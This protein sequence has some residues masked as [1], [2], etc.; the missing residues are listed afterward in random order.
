M[1]RLRSFSVFL[2]LTGTALAS[3]P[4]NAV[5]QTSL[6]QAST[7]AGGS[8]RMLLLDFRADWCGPC[9]VMEAEVYTPPFM[10][11]LAVRAVPVRIDVEKQEKVARRYNVTTLPTIIFADA[12][13][14]EILRHTGSLNAKVLENILQALPDNMRAIDAQASRLAANREDADALTGMGDLL[15]ESGLFAASRG[16]YLRALPHAGKRQESVLNGLAIDN[17]NLRQGAEAAKWL[18]RC[19]KEFPDSEHAGDWRA[20]LLR[21]RALPST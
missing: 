17:L 13:G 8:N 4:G 15:R 14:G 19:L 10:A 20:D 18:R 11:S 1:A 16:Y 6:A 2:L 12:Y 5:W 9:K 3:D 21:A 7:A